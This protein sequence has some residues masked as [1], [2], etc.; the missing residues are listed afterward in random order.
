MSESTD[1]P[2]D[3]LSP[4]TAPGTLEEIEERAKW[5]TVVGWLSI[6]FGALSLTCGGAGIAVAL[7]LLPTIMSMAAQGGDPAPSMT[8]S[9]IAMVLMF[10]GLLWQIPL[11]VAGITTLMRKA[12]GRP[13]H[14]MYAIG[15]A[16]TTIPSTFVM[17]NEQTAFNNSAEVAQWK[18]ENSSNPMAKSIGTD[19]N[20]AWM[21]LGL[22]LNLAWP[23]FCLIWF[24]PSARSE[25]ALRQD[26]EDALV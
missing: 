6:I 4:P 10:L 7:F 11:I 16:I 5:P 20:P 9:P 13:I 12:P 26:E 25:K 14:L 23:T 3:D 1:T 18:A 17:K 8:F 24:L 21:V 15:F 19:P 22:A 2:F